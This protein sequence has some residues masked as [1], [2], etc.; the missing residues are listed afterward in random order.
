VKL[1]LLDEVGVKVLQEGLVEAKM[2]GLQKDSLIMSQVKP[3][4]HVGTCFFSFCS[5]SRE[6]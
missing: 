3:F 2:I 5:S 1:S 4:S 6:E